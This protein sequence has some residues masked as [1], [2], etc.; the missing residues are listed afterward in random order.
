MIAALVLAAAIAIP[1]RPKDFV[2]DNAAALSSGAVS[3]V[4]SELKSYYDAT[5][6]TV[7]VWIGQSTGD[8]PL[9]EWTVDAATK[10]KI[11]SKGK[12]NGAV[13]FLFMKDRKIRIE[14]GYGLEGSLPDASASEIVRNT[15]APKMRAGDV[16]GAVQSGVD[17]MLVTITPSYAQKL[18]RAVPLRTR[19]RN[20]PMPR[21]SGSS[22]SS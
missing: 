10:W 1:P 16:D 13:L 8:Q 22:S 15:I 4:S 2:T 12:D 5:G 9:E 3:S 7:F 17:A 14:V 11:G 20:H 6:N 19:K 18:G 21:A